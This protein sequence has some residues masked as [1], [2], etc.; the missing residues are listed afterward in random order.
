ME[1]EYYIK[2]IIIPNVPKSILIN[3]WIKIF[4]IEEF[5]NE[6]NKDLK[7]KIGN[8]FDVYVRMLYF[9]LK[10]KYLKAITNEKLYRS[11]ILTKEEIEEIKKIKQSKKKDQLPNCL[12]FT[13]SLLTFS[14]D[15]KIAFESIKKSL[16]SKNQYYVIFEIEKSESQK[17]NNQNEGINE[18]NATNIN[19]ETYNLDKKE[20]LFLPFSCFEI[21]E[22]P[23][24]INSKYYQIKI[25]IY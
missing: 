23:Q 7:N 17:N 20:V 19:I 3:Y 1:L 2:Q 10:K 22:E 14:R 12:C 5:S 15:E 18:E 13:K 21:D 4:F 11:E 24:F 8:K 16:E 9:G 6:I 25:K